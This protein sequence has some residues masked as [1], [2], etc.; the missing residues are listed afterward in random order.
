MQNGTCPV[1][2]ANYPECGCEKG[3]CVV[4]DEFGMACD[5]CGTGGHRDAEGWIMRQNGEIWCSRCNE[6]KPEATRP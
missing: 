1:L 3:E 6:N 2:H 4:F 5:E